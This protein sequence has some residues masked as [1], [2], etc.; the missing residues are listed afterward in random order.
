LSADPPGLLPL[1]KHNI[2]DV[3]NHAKI[4]HPH[5]YDP[6][7]I[8]HSPRPGLHQHHGLDGLVDP[9][10]LNEPENEVTQK[11]DPSCIHNHRNA[12]SN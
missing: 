5:Q 9:V 1:I 6:A 12:Q 2:D 8:G 11:T 4:C 7:N 3:W 10:P